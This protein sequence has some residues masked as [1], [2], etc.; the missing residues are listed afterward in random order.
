QK[1]DLGDAVFG[2]IDR[3]QTK[4]IEKRLRA[5]A[6]QKELMAAWTNK[7][8]ALKEARVQQQKEE[9]AMLA[10]AKE[11]LNE[12]RARQFA[13]QLAA[14]RHLEMAWL[15]AMQEHRS[16]R[17]DQARANWRSEADCVLLHDQCADYVRCKQCQ[18][19]LDNVGQS[20]LFKD[21][22]FAP[23]TRYIC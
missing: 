15:A 17:A 6:V 21:S 1:G 22:F 2:P 23:G 14:R 4:L 8:K 9:E 12:E 10:K 13:K 18:R 5:E 11:S 20:N 16:H 19:R 3:S 7:A